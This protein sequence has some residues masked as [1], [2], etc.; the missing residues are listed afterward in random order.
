MAHKSPAPYAFEGLLTE[1]LRTC[2]GMVPDRRR[3]PPAR[4]IVK[5]LAAWIICDDVSEFESHM[6]SQPVRSLRGM[7]GS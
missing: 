5:K 7:S 3:S 4:V 1:V 6:P 2:S